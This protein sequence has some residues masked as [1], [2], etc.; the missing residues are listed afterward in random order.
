MSRSPGLSGEPVYAHPQPARESR[1][2]RPILRRDTDGPVCPRPGLRREPPLA[3]PPE[4]YPSPFLLGGLGRESPLPT[5]GRISLHWVTLARRERCLPNPVHA[6]RPAKNSGASMRAAGLTGAFAI[7]DGAGAF[8]YFADRPVVHLEGL[9]NDYEYLEY[10]ADGH[11]EQYLET[12]EIRYLAVFAF[13]STPAVWKGGYEVV[14]WLEP[15]SRA[16]TGPRSAIEVRHE[17]EVYR[18][19]KALSRGGTEVVLVV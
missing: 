7:G 5:T 3:F 1:P 16:W 18:Q 14:D 13:E 19:R 12:K 17:D 2:G 4:Y 15:S 9:V 11:I 8:G 10:L 6:S